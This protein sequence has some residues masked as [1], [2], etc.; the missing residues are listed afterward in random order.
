MRKMYVTLLGMALATGI[1]TG[2][3]VMASS[4]EYYIEDYSACQKSNY[5]PG[6]FTTGG[7]NAL[8]DAYV[9]LRAWDKNG[10][11]LG[12]KQDYGDPTAEVSRYSSQYTAK[13]THRVYST[14][15]EYDETL[16]ACY[17]M[18]LE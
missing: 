9:K 4:D 17:P 18:T 1:V 2:T 6:A 8:R 12:S 3:S 7:G 16:S 5:D 14:T 10:T 11:L 13:T 15:G